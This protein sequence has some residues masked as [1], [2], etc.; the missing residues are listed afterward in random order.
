M[1]NSYG[2]KKNAPYS[3][4]KD[5]FIF[6]SERDNFFDILIFQRLHEFNG[7]KEIL[8][9]YLIHYAYF[10]LRGICNRLDKEE[11]LKNYQDNFTLLLTSN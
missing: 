11:G 3:S 8:Y 6:I 2:I 1:G 7:T 9:Y 10:Q 5:F 4:P